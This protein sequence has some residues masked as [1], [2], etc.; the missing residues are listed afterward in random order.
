MIITGIESDPKM[1]ELKAKLLGSLLYFI[2]YFYKIRTGRHFSLSEPIGR[3][4][5]HI[6]VC[7]EL[8][9]VFYL[10]ILRLIINLPPGHYKSTILQHFIA[11]AWAHYPDCQFLYLSYSH[12]EASKNTAVIKSIVELPYYH[13]LFGINIPTSSSAKDDFKTNYGGTLK[14]FGSGGAVTGKDAGFPDCARF[15]GAL[16]M[17]DMH[18][19]DEAF[20]DTIR[21]GVKNNYKNTIAQRIR[22]PKVPQIFL[23]QRTHEADLADHFNQGGDGHVWEKVILEGLD[24]AGNALDPNVKT[25]KELEI[26]RDTSEYVFWTQYQQTPQPAG[27]GIFKEKGFYKMEQEPDIIATFITGDTAETDK[28]YNDPTV[29]SFWGVYKINDLQRKE[30]E[31]YALHWIDCIEMRVEPKELESRFLSFYGECCMHKVP[32]R[33]AAIEKKSTGVTLLSVLEGIRGLSVR[34]ILRTKAS[35]SKSARYMEIQPYVAKKLISLPA[36]GKH[37]QMCIE[38]CCKITANN[39]HRHD[40]IADTLYDAVKIALIDKVLINQINKPEQNNMAKE[41]MANYKRID[42]LRSKIWSQ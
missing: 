28:N 39:T 31:C 4:S 3:E 23:G 25:A 34:D 7:R 24:G 13:E 14:A 10:K 36:Y 42:K 27:G 18:K 29:F 32:P 40:D 41:M 35:G 8:T 26:L 12:D 11:W 2:Q 16:V 19:P 20:S 5:H 17:D 38:H 37:T 30:L 9:K 1:A 22:G 6:T 21:E 33:F 15:S